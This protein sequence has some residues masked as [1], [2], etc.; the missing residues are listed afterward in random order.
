MKKETGMTRSKKRLLMILS[1]IAIAATPLAITPLRAGPP[2]DQGVRIVPIG[3]PIWKPVDFHLFAA[4]IGTAADG[5]AEFTT[6]AV[7][8]LPPP[9]HKF[10]PILL[11]GPGVPHPPPY[12]SELANGVANLGFHEGVHFRSSEF[13]EG[14]GVWLAWMNVPMP[15]VAGSSPDSIN[16]PFHPPIIPNTL[17]PILLR[18]VSYLNNKVFDPVLA[19]AGDGGPVPIP[20]LDGNIDP[21]FAGLDGHSHF[22]IFNADNADFGPPGAKPNGSY[23]YRYTM[24]DQSGN[25]WSIS[26]HFSIG[27]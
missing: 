15:G 10:N 25:G 11:V 3:K 5:Y 26:A 21:S 14:I 27:P 16:S 1:A 17:F 19:A 20:P 4:P 12:D 8:L 18:G 13:S 24:L 22:P 6:V 2:P 7:S 9:K 23:E